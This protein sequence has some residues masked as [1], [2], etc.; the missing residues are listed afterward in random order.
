MNYDLRSM[1]KKRRSKMHKKM[2]LLIPRRWVRSRAPSRS[3]APDYKG[4]RW[5]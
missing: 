4:R 1:Q 5:V 3:C 2:A